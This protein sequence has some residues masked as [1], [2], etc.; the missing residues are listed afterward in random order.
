MRMLRNSPYLFIIQLV[1]NRKAPSIFPQELHEPQLTQYPYDITAALS[2][3]NDAMSAAPKDLNCCC[4]LRVVRQ[5]DERLL[6]A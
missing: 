1:E 5:C 6:I 3:Y 4:H 2:C